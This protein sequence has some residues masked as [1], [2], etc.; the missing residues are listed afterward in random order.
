VIPLVAVT[1]QAR[2]YERP[3]DARAIGEIAASLAPPGG[4]LQAFANECAD[5]AIEPGARSRA[6]RVA[7]LLAGAAPVKAPAVSP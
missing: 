1:L 7:R 3:E 2:S 4:T 6:T 5:S